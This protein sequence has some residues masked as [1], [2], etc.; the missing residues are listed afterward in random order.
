VASLTL[1][2]LVRDLELDV[3]IKGKRTTRNKVSGRREAPEKEKW[4]CGKKLDRNCFCSVWVEYNKGGEQTSRKIRA[5]KKLQPEKKP[6]IVAE[7]VRELEALAKF[8][9]KKVRVRKVWDILSP[10]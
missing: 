7:Y 6:R 8:S 5:V 1:P 4:I 9:Q 2:E 3:T 10:H